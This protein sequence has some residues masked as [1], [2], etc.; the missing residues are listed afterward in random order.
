MPTGP[1]LLRRRSMLSPLPKHCEP[2]R[3]QPQFLE[4]RC[5]FPLILPDRLFGA[6]RRGHVADT[7]HSKRY[8]HCCGLAQS[9]SFED[10]F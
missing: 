7:Q 5:C 3:R 10:V 4:I 2:W 9:I 1:Y 8:C 6:R